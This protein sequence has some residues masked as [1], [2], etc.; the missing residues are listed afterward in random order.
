MKRILLLSILFFSMLSARAQEANALLLH[1]KGADPVLYLFDEKPVIR[2]S[3]TDVLFQTKD[4]LFTYPATEVARIT[5]AYC[6]PKSLLTGDADQNGEVTLRDIVLL[7]DKLNG[8]STITIHQTNADTNRNG[9]I[10]KDDL[11]RTLRV[12]NK[13]QAK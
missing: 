4:D 5:S 7:I 9:K 2:F 8:K 11:V 6:D 13:R 3:N 1:L 10:D 12:I